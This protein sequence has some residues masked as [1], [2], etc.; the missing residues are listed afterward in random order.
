M[1]IRWADDVAY[2]DRPCDFC[3][4]RPSRFAGFGVAQDGAQLVAAHCEECGTDADSWM[5]GQG[6]SQIRTTLHQM[7]NLLREEM[8]DQNNDQAAESRQLFEILR[9]GESV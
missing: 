9:Y 8:D 4:D 7:L 1:H 3:S 5:S 6:E 2:F